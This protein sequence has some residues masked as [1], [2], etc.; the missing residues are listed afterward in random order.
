MDPASEDGS[1]DCFDVGK[2]EGE[3]ESVEEGDEN[4]LRFLKEKKLS[5][6]GDKGIIES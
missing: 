6:E 5:L 3:R 2:M 4:I 1:L